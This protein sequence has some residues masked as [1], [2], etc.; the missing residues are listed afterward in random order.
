LEAIAFI[1]LTFVYP[2]QYLLITA[3]A[4]LRGPVAWHPILPIA[5]FDRRSTRDRDGE[6]V[7][8]HLVIL[9]NVDIG[10]SG[11]AIEM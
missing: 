4:Q 3:N 8:V 2:T 9:S 1:T 5:S 10:M 6:R 7:E 11:L